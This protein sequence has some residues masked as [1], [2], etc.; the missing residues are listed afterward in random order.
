[1][2]GTHDIT[3]NISIEDT[4]EYVS[5]SHLRTDTSIFETLQF[6]EITSQTHTPANVTPR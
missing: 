2:I 6:F 4:S 3:T 1:M 5:D